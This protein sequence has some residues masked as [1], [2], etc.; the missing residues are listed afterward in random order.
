MPAVKTQSDD[1]LSP[2]ARLILP[3]LVL[4]LFVFAAYANS[5]D[6]GFLFDDSLLIEINEYLRGWGHIG[7]ILTTSTTAGAHIDGGFYR[8]LQVLLYL[9]AFHLGDG[10][11]FWFHFLNLALHI[12]NTCFV[13]RIGAK[14]GFNLNGAFLAALI[15]GL[16]PIHTEAVTY[17]SGTADP[18]AAFFCLW[19]VIVL[20]PDVTF[21]KILKVIPLFLLGL[22]SKEATVMFPLLVMACLFFVSERRLNPSTYLRT[23]PLWL[24]TLAFVCW[25][26]TAPGLDG[27]Q[28]YD[29][30]YAMPQFSDM[31]IYATQPIYRV[32]TFLATLPNYLQLL[33]WP[34]G[35][36]MERTFAIQSSFR[37][38]IVVSGALMIVC[39]AGHIAYSCKIRRGLA[40]SWGLLW[41]AAAHS[42]DT[43]LLIT[44]NSLFLEH[45]MYLPSVGLFL[46]T[47]ETLAS[48]MKGR[49]RALPALASV[50]ALALAFTFAVK[51]HNQNKIWHDPVSFYNNIFAYGVKSSRAY[52][53]LALYY[54]DRNQYD[55][56]IEQF[57][58]AIETSDIYAETRYNLAVTYLRKSRSK[59]TIGKSIE[60]AKHALEIQPNFYRADELLS[61]I[62]KT[63]LNDPKTAD[64]YDA[65]AKEAY[66][67]KQP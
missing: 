49:P 42:P 60:H 19:A 67:P 26:A 54:S 52:N 45:W 40:L 7:D 39:A 32:Y 22:V 5:F 2:Q 4:A 62:Y 24:I 63:Y 28:S 37:A 1:F 47:A 3:Y 50:A 66:N 12:A 21:K 43:G 15:W 9:F 10:N 25:R 17:M 46:G 20:L 57:L 53:N 48:L 56:A 34:T 64:Y 27:P 33:I 65:K 55:D 13:Y 41:F 58:K 18:L 59:E 14:L 30:F 29:R 8:P 16:H 23:W 38:W 31:K 6:N 36:H 11:V 61:F 51:T 44:M 35:L